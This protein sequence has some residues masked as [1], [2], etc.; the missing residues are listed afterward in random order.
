MRLRSRLTALSLATAATAA[1]L[2]I[3]STPA[4]ADDPLD[5]LIGKNSAVGGLVDGALSDVDDILNNLTVAV[6]S[7]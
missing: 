6:L 3:V 7:G 4:H 1:A 5:S 2:T